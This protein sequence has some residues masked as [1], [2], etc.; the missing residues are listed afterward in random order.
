MENVG[1]AMGIVV[2]SSDEDI[3]NVIMSDDGTGVGIRIPSVLISK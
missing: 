1:I 3:K 2:D